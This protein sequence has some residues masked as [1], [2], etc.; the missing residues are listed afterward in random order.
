MN[1]TTVAVGMLGTNC[2][3]IEHEGTCLVVDPGD[4]AKRIMQA[5]GTHP[6]AGILLTHGH[7]DHI[8]AVD[9]LRLA[10]GAKVY[11]HADDAA[12]LPDSELN[13]SLFLGTAVE[14]QPADVI[15][16]G[17]QKLNLAGL[18]ITVIH[19]PG[20][21]PG[22]VAFDI[23]G[24]TLMAGDTLFHES[25]GRTDFPGGSMTALANS[26]RTLYVLGDRVVYCGHGPST[27]LAHEK[28]HNPFVTQ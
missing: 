9:D 20:H 21:T 8:G 11:I 14:I 25:V 15:L 4:D 28:R 17:G 1:I 23:D 22:G 19:T 27:T 26:I 7:V 24:T 13:L 5:V 10:T 12:M 6:L 16:Q 3:I 18:E 2:H